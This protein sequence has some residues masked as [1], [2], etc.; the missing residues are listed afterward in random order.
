MDVKLFETRPSIDVEESDSS[1]TE[2]FS[3][4][5]EE[6][7]RQSAMP[8]P[9]GE[10]SAEGFNVDGTIDLSP[11]GVPLLGRFFCAAFCRSIRRRT[12][13]FS[14]RWAASNTSP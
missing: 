8:E 11:D 10:A 4:E 7:T 14:L 9:G 5:L 6:L 2:A 1:Q 12:T 3:E 13:L